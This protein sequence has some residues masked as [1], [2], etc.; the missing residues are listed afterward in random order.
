MDVFFSTF[1]GEAGCIFH[2][3]Y[4]WTNLKEISKFEI[5]YYTDYKHFYTDSGKYYLQTFMKMN[6]KTRS[7]C[8]VFK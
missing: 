8:Y 5:G 7:N 6:S 1:S 4:T 3:H 2:I